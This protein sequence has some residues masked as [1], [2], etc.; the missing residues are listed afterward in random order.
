MK[1]Q[2]VLLFLLLSLS[3]FSLPA[4]AA[5]PEY[6]IVDLGEGNITPRGINDYGEVVGKSGNRAFLWKNGNMT[7]FGDNRAWG[8]NNSGQVVGISGSHAFLWENN[9]MTDLTPNSDSFARAINDSGQ[10]VGNLSG[11]GPIQAFFWEN[12]VVTELNSPGDGWGGKHCF[13]YQ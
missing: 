10:I 2:T 8:I 5:L 11:G 6:T 7:Y 3:F 12:N 9:V 1:K 13:I 4:I